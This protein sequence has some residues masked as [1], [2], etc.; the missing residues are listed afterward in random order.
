MANL[1]GNA[2]NASACRSEPKLKLWRSAGLLLT[3]RCNAA[4]EFCYY[5]C[6]PEKNGLM[7]V[8]TAI[9]AWRS[10]RNLAGGPAK[11]HITG[12]EP[13]LYWDRLCEI[14]SAAA[15]QGLGPADMVETNG[16]WA[17][18]EKLALHRL[19]VLDEL[20]VKRLKI[21]CD[22]FHQQYVG[23]ET[24]RRLVEIASAVL[25]PRRVQVRW[26]RYLD[27]SPGPAG[28][29]PADTDRLYRRAMADYP[30]RFAG[31]AA[32]RP[33]ELVAEKTATDISRENCRGD[34]LGA[35]GVHVD[36]YGNVFS[37]TCSGIIIANV[38]QTPLDE[39]WRSFDPSKQPFIKALFEH[40][41]AG[42][43]AEAAERGYRPPAA[44][45]DKCHLC[46]GVRRFFLENGLNTGA[47]GPPD[48]Y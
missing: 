23:I 16:F 33:A 8:E 46:T 1:H 35:K 25:G 22:P 12:G 6:S 17:G 18:D 11:V 37:S 47:V 43:A 44:L 4:C 28:T 26:R 39:I 36:P 24:V 14:L 30:C 7:P 41:P 5:S 20:K 42:L 2:Y 40:G 38:N 15:E 10:L 31:R 3:Y 21:A 29:S 34:F 19:K 27:E 45:A 9:G 48:C 32:G 13:F